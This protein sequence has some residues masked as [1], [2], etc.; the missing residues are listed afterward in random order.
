MA[1]YF[2]AIERNYKMIGGNNHAVK[3]A[4]QLRQT[5][6]DFLSQLSS[7]GKTIIESDHQTILQMLEALEYTENKLSKISSYIIRYNELKD[8]PTFKGILDKNPVT[9]N[10]L[11]EL[12]TE[13]QKQSSKVSSKGIAAKNA[14]EQIQ[15]VL[16]SKSGSE[17]STNS[18][19][20][21][22]S[23]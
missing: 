10:I 21:L 15:N 4:S 12:E 23:F 19:E 11:K 7:R 6:A 13:Y 2:D 22:R 18:D 20:F 1:R 8:D 16:A 17:F 5:Y 14:L 3:I 9:V